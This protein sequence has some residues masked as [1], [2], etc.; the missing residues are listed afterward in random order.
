MFHFLYKT[1]NLING[2]IYY[3]K[4]TTKNIND[5]YLGSGFLLQKAILKYGKENFKREILCF[6]E[7]KELN[8]ELEGLL[9]DDDFLKTKNH[10]NMIKGGTGGDAKNFSSKNGA[11]K[12]AQIAA[13][14]L[15]SDPK[16]LA[17]RN[18]KISERQLTFV[19]NNPEAM[20]L[21][22]ALM[23]A[24]C[25]GTTK[26]NNPQIRKQI[27]NRRANYV[28]KMNTAMSD[29][30]HFDESTETIDEA[31]IR[32]K[33]SIGQFRAMRKKI[34]NGETLWVIA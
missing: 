23:N 15:T 28:K 10:Y 9:I 5:G 18:K 7:T 30:L 14:T 25:A 21:K 8:S 2:K 4:R 22:V 16:K 6:T 32:A 34:E 20:L 12:N 26:E 33:V 27:A 3:G 17:A 1:T 13:K 19:K 29:L 31:L 24:T 11:K